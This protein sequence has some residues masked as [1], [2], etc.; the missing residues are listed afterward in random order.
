MVYHLELEFL[1]FNLKQQLN[2]LAKVEYMFYHQHHVLYH[3][4]F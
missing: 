1:I 3:L 4:I 2:L